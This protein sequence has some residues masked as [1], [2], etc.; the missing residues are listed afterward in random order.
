M[1]KVR[2]VLLV[3]GLTVGCSAGLTAATVTPAVAVNCVFH[4]D[5]YVPGT[6]IYFDTIIFECQADGTWKVIGDMKPRSFRNFHNGR[7]GLCL[8]TA[9]GLATEGAQVLQWGC[10]A[11]H[12]EWWGAPDI[13][14]NGYTQIVNYHAGKCLGTEGRSAGSGAG[15][16]I[17]TCHA[18]TLD[19]LDQWWRKE[20]APNGRTVLRNALSGFV[21]GVTGGST[22]NGARAVQRPFVSG[23]PSQ[24]WGFTPVIEP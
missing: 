13:A 4:G 10:N 9:F 3:V 5:S 20:A 12:W 6:W 23:D 1:G 16:I 17:T 24:T 11:E 8:A 19:H 18:A 21:L 2:A 14:V 7:S 22:G 15:M